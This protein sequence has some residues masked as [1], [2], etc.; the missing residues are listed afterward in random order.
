MA[1]QTSREALRLAQGIA[2][3]VKGVKNVEVV[4]TP[5]FIYLLLLKLGLPRLT[6]VKAGAQDVFWEKNG[7]YT[8]EISTNQLKASGVRLVIVGHSERRAL[9]ETN[10]I[11]NKK[12]KAVLGAGMRA[13]LCVGEAEKQKEVAFPKIIRDELHE[14]LARIKK[15]LFRN[16][17]IAYEP[18]WAVGT[19]RADTPKNVYEITTIIRRELYRMVGKRIASKIPVLYG[20][21]VDEKNAHA[22]VKDGAVDGLLVGGASLNAKKFINIVKAVSEV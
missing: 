6:R 20:G 12:L 16:L 10:E 15:S 11:V 9:W 3:G 21:S 7:A 5:P 4:L 13:V 8:G 22:F 19:G 14:G 2:R 17:I 18:I 1:P